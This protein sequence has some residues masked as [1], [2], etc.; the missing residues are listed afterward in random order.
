MLW[1]VCMQVV[2]RVGVFDT[3]DDASDDEVAG[4]AGVKNIRYTQQLAPKVK[5]TSS[6]SKLLTSDL[7]VHPG[8]SC[9]GSALSGL[10]H[11]RSPGVQDS[12]TPQHHML[13]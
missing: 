11:K 10:K 8:P 4:A 5:V 3:T 13:C 9:P 12:L 2:H 1:W 6:S 7:C